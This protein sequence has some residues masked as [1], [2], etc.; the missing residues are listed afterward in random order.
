MQRSAEPI[1]LRRASLP[2]AWHVGN[3]MQAMEEVPLLIAVSLES[4]RRAPYL[5]PDMSMAQIAVIRGRSSASELSFACETGLLD[6]ERA[7]RCEAL[8]SHGFTVVEAPNDWRYAYCSPGGWQEVVIQ[9]AMKQVASLN[10]HDGEGRM[11][12]D[13][14][15]ANAVLGAVNKSFPKQ[16]F[17]WSN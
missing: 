15:L 11:S 9:Q 8:K 10:T 16:S 2:V 17:P 4:M 12:Y 6:A 5:L 7:A 13:A 1:I 14:E 3:K